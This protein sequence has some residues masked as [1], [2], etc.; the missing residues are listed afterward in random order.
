MVLSRQL[1]VTTGEMSV[2]SKNT[3]AGGV[4]PGVAAV[5]S[6]CHLLCGLHAF[7]GLL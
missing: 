5:F 3:V 6:C 1:P 4:C 2:L 7:P